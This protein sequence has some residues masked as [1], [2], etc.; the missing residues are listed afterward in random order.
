ME[1]CGVLPPRP[2]DDAVPGMG[3]ATTLDMSQLFSSELKA[4]AA[5]ESMTLTGLRPTAGVKR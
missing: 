5:A 3:N 1:R 4:T 2:P